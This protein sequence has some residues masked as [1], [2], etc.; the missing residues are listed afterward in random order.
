LKSTL[1]L[2]LNKKDEIKFLNALHAMGIADVGV[3]DPV[4]G[5]VLPLEDVTSTEQGKEAVALLSHRFAE[6]YRTD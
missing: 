6:I 4:L 2:Q 3:L 5:G 1:N